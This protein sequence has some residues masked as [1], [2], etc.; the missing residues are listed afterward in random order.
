[1]TT[2]GAANIEAAAASRP[3]TMSGHDRPTAYYDGACSLCA[4][5]I[6]FY[7]RQNGADRICWVDTS[8]IDTVDVALD[9]SRE[10][11]L[12]RFTV[13]DADGSLVSGGRAFTRIWMRLPLF[14]WLATVFEIQPFTWLLG[15]AYDFFL[16]LRPRLHGLA[17]GSA[18]AAKVKSY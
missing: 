13:R 15:Q 14:R 4:R 16:K 5:E 6:G 7:R 8:D 2:S 1:M 12:A 18:G 17:Q 11:A 10:Q 3:E 9:L